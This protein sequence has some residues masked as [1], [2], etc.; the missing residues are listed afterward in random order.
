MMRALVVRTGI[1]VSSF[2]PLL[3]YLMMRAYS[4]QHRCLLEES[5]L[6]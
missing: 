1:P 4:E 3:V 6:V 5:R 2:L